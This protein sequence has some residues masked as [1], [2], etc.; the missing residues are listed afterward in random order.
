MY[1]EVTSRDQMIKNFYTFHEQIGEGT[2]GRVSLA[3][4]KSTGREYA[5]K[6]IDKGKLSA[7]EIENL[8]LEIDI[9]S[10][11]DHPNVVRTFEVYDEPK[12]LYIVME[13]MKGGEL[14]EKIVEKDHYSEKEAADTIRPVVEA[15]KYCHEMGI[16]HRDLKPENLLYSS[17][18]EDAIIKITDFGLA[19]FYD[20]DLMTTAC[21]TPGYVAPEILVGKGYGLEVDYWSLGV[22]LYIM[23]SGFPPFHEDSNEELFEKIKAGNFEFPSPYWDDISEMAKDLISSCLKVNPRERF[24]AHEILNHRWL[25]GEETPRTN[26]PKVTQKIR[27]FNARRRWRKYGTAAIAS[28]KF[29]AVAREAKLK[30]NRS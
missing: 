14:F 9:I 4:C 28:N 30:N 17:E 23:L 8:S 20:D 22:I 29:M 11:V 10:Q 18:E 3:F 16:V 6:C 27:E 24:S 13:F 15:I 19:R 2:F 5:I 25:M 1:K 21:G 7:D 26:M 12:Q